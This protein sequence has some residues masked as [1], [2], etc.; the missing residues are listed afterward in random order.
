[1]HAQPGLDCRHLSTRARGYADARQ[2]F[3][4]VGEP[5][6]FAVA[7][8]V[9]RLAGEPP[10]GARSRENELM[11]GPWRATVGAWVSTR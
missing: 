9:L 5:F 2:V 6:V 11:A 4:A 1:M 7:E 10:G 8:H 3:A